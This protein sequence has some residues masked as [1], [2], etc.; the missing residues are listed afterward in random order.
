MRIKGRPV[1]PVE[2]CSTLGTVGDIICVDLG[3]YMLATKGGVQQASS[4]HV[5]FTTD[6]MAYRATYRVDGQPVWRSA[7][8]PANGTNT[9]SPYVVLATRS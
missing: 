3:A 6:E 1:I 7:V 5:A 9:Q 2:Y 8:T 4:M